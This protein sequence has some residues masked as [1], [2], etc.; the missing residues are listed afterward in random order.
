VGRLTATIALLV[1]T[2]GAFSAS[3]VWIE[4]AA[5]QKVHVFVDASN[6]RPRKNHLSAWV[7][8]EYIEA[9]KYV[10]GESTR[11]YRSSLDLDAFDCSRRRSATMSK[12]L[13]SL[14]SGG[15]GAF[16]KL[17]VEADHLDWRR[18]GSRTLRAATLKFVCDLAKPKRRQ[19]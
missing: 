6:V 11:E 17:D 12:T 5:D 16:G 18:P 1:I 19:S 8:Y 15:G 13:Y 14:P 9:Q 10:E 4:V 2:S 3:P 7:M